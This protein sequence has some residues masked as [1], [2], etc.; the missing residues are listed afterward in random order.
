MKSIW[1]AISLL[2]A[3]AA[4]AWAAPD[5]Q[6][7]QDVQ[8]AQDAQDVQYHVTVSAHGA[9]IFEGEGRAEAQRPLE[10]RQFVLAQDNAGHGQAFVDS[11]VKVVLRQLHRDAAQVSSQLALE[12]AGVAGGAQAVTVAS[13]LGDA[14]RA[15]LAGY[16]VTLVAS[17]MPS[18]VSP[19]LPEDFAY[20]APS[21]QL[22]G[23][24][25]PRVQFDRGAYQLANARLQRTDGE[26]YALVRPAP[27]S[28][29]GQPGQPDTAV[30]ARLLQAPLLYTAQR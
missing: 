28:Q 25:L 19:P 3:A 5:V 18:R 24:N 1:L 27:T 14:A 29:P 26:R 13:R 23:L 4:P 11:G 12:V 6:D 7:V 30:A 2:G 10:L 15:E 22:D 8:G 9:V 16:T 17:A 21:L 20:L